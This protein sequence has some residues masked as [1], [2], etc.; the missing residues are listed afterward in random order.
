[1]L[2]MADLELEVLPCIIKSQSHCWKPIC[3]F[4][5]LPRHKI[6]CMR[7][8]QVNKKN[9]VLFFFTYLRGWGNKVHTI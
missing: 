2:N 1:M 5:L 6:W 3:L 8:E 7:T 9:N 4:P